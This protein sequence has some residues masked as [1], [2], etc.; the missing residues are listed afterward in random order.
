MVVAPVGFPSIDL[1][2]LVRYTLMVYTD[3]KV[4]LPLFN[5]DVTKQPKSLKTSQIDIIACRMAPRHA[6]HIQLFD[7]Y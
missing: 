4:Q 6:V 1:A 7:T 2:P 5:Q 3:P